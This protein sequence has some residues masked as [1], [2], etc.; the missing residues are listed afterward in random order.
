GSRFVFMQSME[1]KY[2]DK[3]DPAFSTIDNPPVPAYPQKIKF[4]SGLQLNYMCNKVIEITV[5]TDQGGW[6]FKWQ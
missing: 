5:D 2:L 1:Q 6:T 3:I 4:G